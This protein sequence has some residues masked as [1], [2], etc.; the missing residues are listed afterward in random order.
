[1]QT[2]NKKICGSNIGNCQSLDNNDPTICS[3]CSAGNML[4]ADKKS[5]G[6]IIEFCVA[7]NNADP[8]KCGSCVNGYFSDGTG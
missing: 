6:T 2:V 1:M 5:C 7:L 8:T 3:S 4:T